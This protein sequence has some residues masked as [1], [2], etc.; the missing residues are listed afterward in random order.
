MPLAC[1]VGKALQL[2]G[3]RRAGIGHPDVAFV[4]D[5]EAMGPCEESAPEV[6]HE[7]S[8]EIELEDGIHVRAHAA[9]GATP[10]QH[11]HVSAAWVRE[12]AG[13][14]APRPPLGELG[15]FGNREIVAGGLGGRV[16]GNEA[17][18]AQDRSHNKGYDGNQ[19][20]HEKGLAAS[21]RIVEFRIV[22]DHGSGSLKT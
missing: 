17:P 8:V 5:K 3:V 21:F 20:R 15:P 18:Q 4:I 6:R 16:G 2:P 10:I 22:V 14:R 1:S 13:D 12:N 19:R 9:I 7:V 11:P